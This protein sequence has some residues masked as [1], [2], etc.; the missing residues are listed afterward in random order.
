MAVWTIVPDSALLPDEPIKSTD[1][2]AIKNNITALAEGASGAPR[3]LTAAYND[4][5]VTNAKL[6]TNAVTNVKVA[7]GTLGTEKFQTGTTER[8]WVLARTSGATEG[9]LGSYALMY[10]LTSNDGVKTPGTNLSG[11]SLVYASAGNHR[12][13]TTATGTWKCLGAIDSDSATSDD[14]TTLFLR[15]A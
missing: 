1:H 10:F 9:V 11:G 15:I 12:S 6:A 5:S 2:I 14:R 13:A 8:D 4:L 7:N 3:I